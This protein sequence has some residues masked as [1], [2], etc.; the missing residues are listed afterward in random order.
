M[1]AIARGSG[2]RWLGSSLCGRLGIRR[3]HGVRGFGDM[4]HKRSY[5]SVVVR[6]ADG[7]LWGTAYD[8]HWIGSLPPTCGAGNVRLGRLWHR[9]FIGAN[10]VVSANGI[11]RVT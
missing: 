2:A 4:V 1:E 5:W 11:K 10:E 6:P 3:D 8:I 7:L 9:F